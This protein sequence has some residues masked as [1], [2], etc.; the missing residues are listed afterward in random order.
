MAQSGSVQWNGDAA[1][2]IARAAA[3]TGLNRG[4]ERLRGLALPLTPHLDGDLEGSAQVHEATSTSVEQGSQV[5]YD[6]P[7]AVIQHESLDFNHTR[8]PNPN[9]QAKYLEQPAA[10]N[11]AEL[12]GIVAA[13][14]RRGL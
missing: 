13:S 3:A 11:K 14:L 7:Y 9:A 5:Q 4:A 2:L 10:E 8:D 6:T 1:K 12:M